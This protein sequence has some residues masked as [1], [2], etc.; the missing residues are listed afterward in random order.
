MLGVYTADDLTEL[1]LAP[2]SN[3]AFPDVM[4]R[5]FVAV[6]TV[7]YVGQPV[8]AVVAEDRARGADAADLVL[9]DYEPLACVVDAEAAARDEVVLFPEHGTNV[10]AR[11]ASRRRPTSP[12]ARSSSPSGSSTSG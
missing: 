4:R 3:P 8:V 2:H 6:G 9:V 5:P 7:R 12:D 1:G 10:V 11:F